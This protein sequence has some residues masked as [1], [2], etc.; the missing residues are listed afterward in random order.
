MFCLAVI[1]I[2]H[3]LAFYQAL[4]PFITHL[5]TISA[6]RGAG[7]NAR[8]REAMHFFVDGSPETKL[9]LST[10]IKKPWRSPSICNRRAKTTCTFSSGDLPAKGE[11]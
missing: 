1:K 8:W 9:F 6:I 4:Q 5:Q 7:K 10:V 11:G 3:P 2:N